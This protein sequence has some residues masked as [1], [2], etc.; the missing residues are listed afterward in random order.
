MFIRDH[1]E[2]RPHHLVEAV[3]MT[4]ITICVGITMFSS[5]IGFTT[6]DSK[7]AD[8]FGGFKMVNTA[9]HHHQDQAN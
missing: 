9:H 5:D 1:Y 7:P 4:V 8:G 3:A 6:L 2:I